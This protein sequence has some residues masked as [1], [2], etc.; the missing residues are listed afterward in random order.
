[1]NVIQHQLQG[2]LIELGHLVTT[3]GDAVSGLLDHIVPSVK[4]C[5]S[6]SEYGVRYE[7]AIA[8]AA[9]AFAV[10][11]ECTG[12]VQDLMDEVRS[13]NDAITD[14][15]RSRTPSR[16]PVSPVPKNRSKSRRSLSPTPSGKYVTY[17][18]SLHGN[19][20]ALSMILHE[21]FLQTNLLSDD[22]LFDLVGVAEILVLY[23]F[24]EKVTMVSF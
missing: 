13:N 19:A 12:F 16:R 7:A 21:S 10:P 6:H 1:M 18:Y 23:Q 22:N 3:L 20:V 5:L 2:A 11:R 17:Q 15:S 4:L 9:I 24:D 14:L 8:F